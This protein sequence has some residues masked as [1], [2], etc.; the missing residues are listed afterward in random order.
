[1]DYLQMIADGSKFLRCSVESPA[2]ITEISDGKSPWN[3][4][5]RNDIFL[6]TVTAGNPEQK[7]ET[8][9]ENY[10]ISFLSPGS[11]Q[12][13]CEREKYRDMFDVIY[14]GGQWVSYLVAQLYCAYPR[15]RGWTFCFQWVADFPERTE[16]NCAVNRSGYFRSSADVDCL[17]KKSLLHILPTFFTENDWRGFLGIEWPSVDCKCLKKRSGFLVAGNREVPWEE[18]RLLRLRLVVENAVM[19]IMSLFSPGL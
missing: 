13:I 11:F 3:I 16:K 1:M 6:F 14:I 17:A 5:L 4:F 10:R 19:F 18:R 9:T 15:Y 7:D 12:K 2:T 8:L